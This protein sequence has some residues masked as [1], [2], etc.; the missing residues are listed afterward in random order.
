MDNEP[1][2][3][4]IT[5]TDMHPVETDYDE[6]LQQF[7]NYATAVKDVDP[8]AQVTGPVSWGWNGYF[9]SARDRGSDR[10]ATHADRRAHGNIAFIPWFLRQVAQQDA[11]LGRRT[12]DVLDVHF[13]PQGDGI[14]SARTD[15]ETDALRLRS[16]RALWDSTYIDESWINAPIQL[17]PRL[18][19]WVEHN[20]PG[21]KIGITE[22]N[23]GA[24]DHISGA[25]AIAEILGIF[26]RE[27]V[28]LAC[29]WTCPPLGSPAFLAYKIYRNPDDLG[30]GFG[31]RSVWTSSSNPN[32]VS[33]FGGMD[34]RF[35]RPTLMLINKSADHSRHVVLV[36][37]HWGT[38]DAAV[39][40]QLAGDHPRLIQR[41][42]DLE[43]RREH[44]NITLP[45]SSVTLL[46]SRMSLR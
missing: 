26:G 20:Y 39:R 18:R 33:C 21:T 11:K 37:D 25:L 45:P 17:I 42:A 41:Q 23:F 6:M 12:L 3:W 2:L 14:Y 31:D 1:D 24:E 27:H 36:L 35:H 16:T 9:F 4:D 15:T 40:Y 34:T 5:H 29:Y 46:S 8:T 22:W 19:Q 38:A 44:A 43:I 10:F 28:D 13:Y 7:L 32:A 30:N